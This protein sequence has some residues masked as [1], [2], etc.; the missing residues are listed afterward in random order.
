MSIEPLV[1]SVDDIKILRK[2]GRDKAYEIAKSLP[3][4][5]E[6]KKILVFR[7]DFEEYIEGIRQETIKRQE[8]ANGNKKDTQ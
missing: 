1:Y 6:E 8:N 7:K 2:C 5:R 3:H 4:F